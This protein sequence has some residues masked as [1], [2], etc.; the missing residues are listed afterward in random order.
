ALA[1]VANRQELVAHAADGSRAVQRAVLLALARQHAAEIKVFLKHDDE[2]FR[3]EA[4]RAIYETPIPDAMQD[5]A[6]LVYDNDADSE[7]IDWRAINAARMIGQVEQGEALVHMA[8]QPSHSRKIRLE[9]LAVLAEWRQPHGQCRI[10]GN[11]RQ[12]DH[13]DADI[14][15]QNFR[16]SADQ[17]LADK[18]TSAATSDTIAQLGLR[19]KAPSLVQLV[20]NEN[21]PTAARVAA[22]NALASLEV[23]ELQQALTAIH[24]DAPVALRK[25]A[26]AL[27]SHTSPEQA[28]PVLGSLLSNASVGEQQAACEALGNLQHESA[29]EL[30]RGWLQRL[31][32]GKVDAAIALDVLEAASKHDALQPLVLVHD[33]KA[34]KLGALGPFEVCIE[35]GDHQ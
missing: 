5:L 20:G 35:G 8:T 10:I 31:D 23:D 34:E 9:A 22:L 28:V 33:K 4:A 21:M 7:R 15:A 18:V 11:W 12:C 19:E 16:G 17:L 13:P 32:A 2:Q 25:R 30:L 1:E 27:L 24:D 29:T 3:Y 14:V 26:V 6:L